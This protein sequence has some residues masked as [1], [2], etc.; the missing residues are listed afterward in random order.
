MLSRCFHIMYL[1]PTCCL[2][3]VQPSLRG[4]AE[5]LTSAMVEFY[6]MNQAKFTSDQHP[7][8]IYS[9]RE[10]SKWTRALYEG[11]QPLD[12][13]TLDELVRLWLHEVGS[14]FYVFFVVQQ[15]ISAF[16]GT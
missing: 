16:A 3:A 5:P 14:L 8:Y 2:F 9:P 13:V 10:L 15:S 4:Y 6:S 11:I 1:C 7:H 12:S